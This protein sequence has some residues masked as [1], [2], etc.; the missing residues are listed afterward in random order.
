MDLHKFLRDR[1]KPMCHIFRNCW[2]IAEYFLWLSSFSLLWFLLFAFSLGELYPIDAPVWIDLDWVPLLVKSSLPAG[3][4]FRD[5]ADPGNDLG[6]KGEYL[7]K[8]HLGLEG[9]EQ[10]GGAANLLPYLACCVYS[11]IGHSTRTWVH[12][13]ILTRSPVLS[14]WRSL[15]GSRAEELLRLRRGPHWSLGP[16]TSYP[17]PF[18]SYHSLFISHCLQERPSSFLAIVNL[19]S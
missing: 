19:R 5:Q 11:G 2:F 13:E 6:H 8:P 7:S 14:F 4:L 17:T 9:Q 12:R 18:E 3:S 10:L 15:S 1:Q 16:P